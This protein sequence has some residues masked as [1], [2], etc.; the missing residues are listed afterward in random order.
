MLA[1]HTMDLPAA[2]EARLS[3]EQP[4]L[5]AVPARL[6]S[7]ALRCE[8][9]TAPQAFLLRSAPTVPEAPHRVA[10]QASER[11]REG[12]GRPP[13]RPQ[14]LR[15]IGFATS[16]SDRAPERDLHFFQYIFRDTYARA[17]SPA[18]PSPAAEPRRSGPSDRRK[19][20]RSGP[21]PGAAEVVP[22]G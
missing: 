4:T 13:V 3:A 22:A 16:Q 18:A 17:P 20:A 15:A 1:A 9:Q 11:A 8:A 14:A 12:S 19:E 7:L 5:R 2:Q 21:R 6:G 10:E